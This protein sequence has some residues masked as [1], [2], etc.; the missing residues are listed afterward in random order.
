MNPHLDEILS[1]DEEMRSRLRDAEQRA[2]SR[3]EQARLERERLRKQ[4]TEAL[5]QDSD[6]EVRAILT[7]LPKS[8]LTRLPKQLIERYGAPPSGKAAG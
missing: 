3:L 2:R 1:A 8:E 4:R 5:A 6:D 7:E